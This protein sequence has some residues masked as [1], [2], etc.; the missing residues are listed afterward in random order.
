MEAQDYRGVTHHLPDNDEFVAIRVV[1]LW[2][3]DEY[4]GISEH[5]LITVNAG[6]R[7]TNAQV[8]SWLMGGH[9]LF[10]TGGRH[11]TFEEHGK[12][13]GRSAATYAAEHYGLL[14]DTG[15][16]PILEYS[17]RADDMALDHP[18]GMATLVKNLHTAKIPLETVR[19]IHAGWFDALYLKN[20]GR[21]VF[22]DVPP[23]SFRQ[24]ALAWL[25]G[26]YGNDS[27]RHL[28]FSGSFADAVEAIGMS[29]VEVDE[30]REIQRFVD[31]A[32]GAND[33]DLEGLVLAMQMTAA[34]EQDIISSVHACL[35][36]KVI[37]QQDFMAAQRQ[38]LANATYIKDCP[39]VVAVMQSDNPEM[40]KAARR[41]DPALQ[42]FVQQRGSGHIL[43][44]SNHTLDM[45]PILIRLRHAEY[46]A[47]GR[48]GQLPWPVLSKAGTIDEV[49]EWFGFEKYQCVIGI[50][51]S[52]KK[53]KGIRKTRLTL[54]RVTACIA[55]GAPHVRRSRGVTRNR[56]QSRRKVA[57]TA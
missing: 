13:D 12:G 31:R 22:P 56:Q 7:L 57:V 11:V 35:D 49:P 10:G 41:C 19:A 9:L 15:L 14:E 50:Y 18:F 6:L 34:R 46:R 26:R 25:V 42:V 55:D 37:V 48:K 29:T 2:G 30:V 54:K 24:I 4:P 47:S 45:R 27:H 52:S 38:F 51:N 16:K 5:P 8:A 44:F 33:F 36:S 32:T 43:I 1:E 28:V 20:T 17:L 21:V 23:P 53:T 3:A 40:H 39:L